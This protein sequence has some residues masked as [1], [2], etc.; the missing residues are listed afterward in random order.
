MAIRD[1]AP[2]ERLSVI[3]N[4]CGRCGGSGLVPF[5]NEATNAAD[6]THCGICGGT[7][8]STL[9]LDTVGAQQVSFGTKHY[10]DGVASV[11]SAGGVKKGKGR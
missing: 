11:R 6:E 7:G 10:A 8:S 2:S 3:S 9:R 5:W 4:P 1:R